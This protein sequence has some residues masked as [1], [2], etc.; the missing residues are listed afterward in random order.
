[1][2]DA[3]IMYDKRFTSRDLLLDDEHDDEEECE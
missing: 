3:D 2:P 1:M